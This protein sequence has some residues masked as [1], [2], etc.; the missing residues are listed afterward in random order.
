MKKLLALICVFAM[1]LSLL[2]AACGSGDSGSAASSGETASSKT[3]SASPVTEDSQTETG[4]SQAD[5]SE[6]TSASNEDPY[7]DENGDFVNKN[8]VE[9]KD[10]WKERKEFRVLVYSNKV[11]TTYF[12]EEIE[13]LYETTDDKIREAVDTRNKEIEDKY[14]IK[15][16]AVT[17][18]DVTA[19]MR[20]AV[21]DTSDF[22]AAMPFMY[23]AAVFAQD[24]SLFDLREFDGYLDIDAPW[25][26]QN[27]NES[28]SIAGK[29]YFT[30]G[31]I[32]IMQKIVS[33]GVAFNKKLM[34]NYYPD[35]DM[36]QLVD[37][38][39]WTYDTFY[40]MAKNVTASVSDDGIM[41]ENDFWGCIGAGAQLYYGSGE[42]LCGKD[43]ND[44]PIITIGVN[45]ERSVNAMQKVLGYVSESGTWTISPTN[46]TDKTDIWGKSVKMFG[47]DQALFYCFA[48]SA[49]KKFRPYDVVYGVVPVPKYNE[50]QEYYYARCSNV[51]YGV[52]IPLNVDDPEFSAYML[53]LMAVGGKNHLTKAYYEAVL[54]GKDANTLDDERMLDLIFSHIHY[55]IAHVYRFT[56]LENLFNLSSPDEFSAALQSALPVVEGKIDEI[57]M[58]YEN[59]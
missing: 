42:T 45:N 13:S 9:F 21:A 48:F 31:D 12:S 59:Q 43:A 19:Q 2:L 36:Y 14:G 35:V 39:L 55:D 44:I 53:D 37:D 51:A 50:D 18:D 41:D 25:W 56:E 8:Q 27:A 34:E 11:Q 10:E 20:V 4:D 28:L 32:S 22:D 57:V 58:R 5:V 29:I 26:D 30:T 7:K 23:S 33:G 54:K 46:F 38:G 52:C 3:E 49:L 47:E 6:E 24:G 40:Q 1:T 16:K 17:V 15:I